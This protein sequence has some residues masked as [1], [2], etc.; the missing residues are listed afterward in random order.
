ME[1][2]ETMSTIKK[3]HLNQ[4]SQETQFAAR[5]V[6]LVWK[7]IKNV[8]ISGKIETKSEGVQNL[9]TIWDEISKETIQGQLKKHFPN[10][11]VLSEETDPKPQDPLSKPRLWVIDELDGTFNAS[12]DKKYFAIAIGFL[13]NGKPISGAVYSPST[14]ELFYGEIGVG[15]FLNGKQ[16]H[17][18]Q[19]D[20]LST[21]SVTTNAS[22]SV[23]TAHRHLDILKALETPRF[24]V[25]GSTVLW[26]AEVAAGRHE[27]GF[28]LDCKPWDRAAVEP[29][30][31]QAGASIRGVDGR[32]T[33]ILD[34]DIVVGSGQLV[35]S[36]I[37][38]T[39]PL[40]IKWNFLPKTYRP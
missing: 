34:S 17:V 14:N 35:D 30:L 2:S 12:R 36:F 32:P 19:A 8:S 28:N 10:D 6:L 11:A 23:E 15:A 24:E 29:I 31:T 39:M 26:L 9:V 1:V 22:Y 7:N 16:I 18:R 33:T 27:L 3:L 21:S 40:L 13:K 20:K 38:T 4:F 25:C 37:N 5:T